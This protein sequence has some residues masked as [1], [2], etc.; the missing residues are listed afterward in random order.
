MELTPQQKQQIITKES[1]LG[2]GK[3]AE[4]ITKYSN[5]SLD[6]FPSMAAEKRSMISGRLSSMPNPVE[7]QEWNALAARLSTSANVTGAAASQLLQSLSAYISNWSASRPN[8]NHV[9]E[10]MQIYSSIEQRLRALTEAEEEAD[11]QQIINGFGD[12]NALLRHLEKYPHTSHKAQIDDNIWALTDKMSDAGLD[13]YIAKMPMGMHVAE[14]Q[15]MKAQLAN[16]QIRQQEMEQI[17]SN[18]GSYDANHLFELIEQGVLIKDELIANDIM[19]EEIYDKLLSK[20]DPKNAPM[21]PDVNQIIQRSKPECKP[22]FTDVY[23]FGIPSTGK[24]CVLMGMTYTPNLHI[25]LASKGGDYAQALQMYIEAGELMPGTPLDFVINL[26]GSINLPNAKGVITEH[27]VNLIEMSGEEFAHKITNNRGHVFSFEDMGTGTTK[28]LANDNRKA[29]FIIIDPTADTIK[30]AHEVTKYYDEE[31][32]EPVKGIE[33]T[34][35][36][37][38]MLLQKFVD[39]FSNPANAEIMKKVDS[40]NIIVTK[41][42]VLGPREER[43][44]K[45]LEL[46]NN[47]YASFILQPLINLGAKF[48]INMATKNRPNLYTFSLGKFY[49]G[50]LYDYEA[51]DANNL[52]NAIFNSTAGQKQGGGFFNSFK[53]TVG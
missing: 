35:V 18:P 7:Q 10:A 1:A 13:Q 24:T 31:T 42:D 14:A 17:R 48:N 6:D 9:D 3:I 22:G 8:G 41:A 50:G 30:Y 36:N 20:S 33:Q 16:Y 49:I 46:F 21:L 37:Q 26:E 51:D 27:K 40:I 11:W 38:R 39:M 45:A 29:F 25:N 28:L 32:G 12:I 34:V 43:M 2:A 4:Y 53:N 19:T 15:Q 23:F 44:T 5:L 47:K 52:V